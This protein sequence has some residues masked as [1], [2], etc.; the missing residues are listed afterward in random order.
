M[1]ALEMAVVAAV[2]PLLSK[3]NVNHNNSRRCQPVGGYPEALPQSTNHEDQPRSQD[4][5]SLSLY[6]FSTPP[7]RE[8]DVFSTETKHCHLVS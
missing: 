2:A 6:P 1:N 7:E 5:M 4:S 3:K 8:E